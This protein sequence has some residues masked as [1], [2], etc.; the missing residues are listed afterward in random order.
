[1]ETGH[2]ARISKP[3]SLNVRVPGSNPRAARSQTQ[4]GQ[5][6][7]NDPRGGTDT[8]LA[9]TNECSA[10][11]MF[12]ECLGS[13]GGRPE[14]TMYR[15]GHRCR[16][17]FEGLRRRS[18]CGSC[19]EAM[20]VLGPPTE[21]VSRTG[22]PAGAFSSAVVLPAPVGAV[23]FKLSSA[24]RNDSAARTSRGS[25]ALP[26]VS[27]VSTRESRPAPQEGSDDDM[28][29]KSTCEAKYDS[30]HPSTALCSRSVAVCVCM[31]KS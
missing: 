19:R 9:C 14:T 5:K 31:R 20:A 18:L 23:A 8:A 3:P 7:A 17:W 2:G 29:E 15:P 24:L 13:F 4:T 11:R 16:C 25:C 12:N 27:P 26:I 10:S 21:S 1:M 6:A 30:S 28:A 22:A